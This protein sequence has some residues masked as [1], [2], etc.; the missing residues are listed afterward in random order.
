MEP[1]HVKDKEPIQKCE[2]LK[3]EMSQ[4]RLFVQTFEPHCFP[5]AS[6]V[7]CFP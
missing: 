7:V 4:E 5:W 2:Q 3:M 6:F 1:N